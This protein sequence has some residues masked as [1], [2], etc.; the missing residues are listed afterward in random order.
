MDY[1]L[2]V[3]KLANIFCIKSILEKEPQTSHNLFKTL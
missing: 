2:I 3:D 1:T